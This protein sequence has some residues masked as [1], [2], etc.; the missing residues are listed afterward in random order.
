M[1]RDQTL[2]HHTCTNPPYLHTTLSYANFHLK[3]IQGCHSNYTRT[4]FTRDDAVIA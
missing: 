3:A 2:L 4:H 1:H